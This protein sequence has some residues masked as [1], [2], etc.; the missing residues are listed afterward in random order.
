MNRV[1][2][3]RSALTTSAAVIASTL[4]GCSSLSG[5]GGSSEYGC[6]APVGV[7]CESVSGTYYNALQNNLPSQR[8]PRVPG[9]TSEG[10][11]LPAAPTGWTSDRPAPPR[12]LASS[13]EVLSPS[14]L[15]PS[16]IRSQG[17]V[18]RLWFKPWEDADRDLYDQGYVYVQ[19]DSGRWLIDHAQ[20]RIRDAY[21]PVHPPRPVAGASTRAATNAAK[22]ALS[23]A[24][25]TD[26]TASSPTDAIQALQ[27]RLRASRPNEDPQ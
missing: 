25:P 17:K 24:M 9:P 8:A 20:R 26:D 14:S 6:K 15:D 4:S 27:A 23:G 13:T 19:I 11:S 7:K 1:A 21:A 10:R 3:A 5:V 18:L 2:T 16:P 12:P 22:P